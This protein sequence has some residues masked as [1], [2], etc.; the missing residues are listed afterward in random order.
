MTQTNPAQGQY[1][2]AQQA[3]HALLKRTHLRPKI[4]V[5]L[6]SGLGAFAESLQGAMA[7]PFS[8]IEN[9]PASAVQ[10]HAGKLVIGLAG[11]VP[12]AAMQGRVHFYEGHTMQQVIFPIRVLRALGCE[13][14]IITNAAG[15]ISEK[16]EPGCLVV[17][18]DH[19]NFQGTNPLIGPND[20]RLG[21]RFFDMSTAYDRAYREIAMREGLNLGIKMHEGVYLAVSGPSYETPAEIR[22]FR[23]LG[24]DVV[25]MSTVPEVIAARHMGMRVL[26]IS[27]VTNLASGLSK[28]PLS[29]E[30]VLETGARVRGQFTKL[31]ETVI[32]LIANEK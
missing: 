31:L 19:I 5:V 10:G 20:E 4:A 9:F 13:S 21:L 16:L 18:T 26:T 28:K 6:G 23:M 32:P 17:I 1:E 29:H 2:L 14:A 12:V 27:C 15:G 25:G 30:E 8:E 7:V 22:A 3:A 24:A 11:D